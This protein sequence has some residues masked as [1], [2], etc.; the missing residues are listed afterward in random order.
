MATNV[1]EKLGRI[2]VE[3]AFEGS[4]EEIGRQSLQAGGPQDNPTL[5]VLDNLNERI[6][7]EQILPRITEEVISEH[8]EHPIG[9]HSDDL[10]RVLHYFRR[11]ALPEKYAIIEI[12]RNEEWCLGKLSGE[13]GEPPNVMRDTS[14]DSLEAAQHAVFTRRVEELRSKFEEIE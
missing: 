7:R 8:R 10:Q 6:A 1:F 14:F 2:I 5:E 3:S 4:Y 9:Q 12:D 11:Q 13:R